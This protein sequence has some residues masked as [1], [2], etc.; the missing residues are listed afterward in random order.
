MSETQPLMPDERRPTIAIIGMGPRGLSVLERIAVRIRDGTMPADRRLVL[1]DAVQIGTGRIWRTDQPRHLLMNTVVSHMSMYSG[2]A[3]D[4]PARAGAGPS[5]YDWHREH[6]DA[7]INGID[8]NGYAKRA[9][10]ARYLQDV[11]QSILA[12]L[13][14]ATVVA[15]VV[16]CVSELRRAHGRYSLVKDDG[17]ELAGIDQV[18]LATGHPNIRPDSQESPLTNFAQQTPGV[19]FVPGDSAA[20]LPLAAV[21]AGTEVGLIGMGLGFY[22]VLLSLTEGRGG[23]FEQDGDGLRYHA[24]GREPHIVA[25]SRSGVPMLARGANQKPPSHRYDPAYFTAEALQAARREATG[26]YG[27]SRLDFKRDVYPLFNAELR[28]V[29][30]KAHARLQFGDDAAEAFAARHDA[31]ELPDAPGNASLFAEYGLSDIKPLDVFELGRPF[32]GQTYDSRAAYRRNLLQLLWDDLAAARE[33]NVDNPLK[34]A[35]DA[36]RDVRGVLRQAVDFEGLTPQAH[37]YDFLG[38]FAPVIAFLSAGPPALRIEQT[39]ALIEAGVLEPVGPETT[40]AGDAGTGTFLAVSG[41]VAGAEHFV[42]TLI[43]TRVPVP[44]VSRDRSQLMRNLLNTGVVR[45]H[46]A[47]DADGPAFV[48]GGVDVRPVSFNVIG[49]DS[50][51]NPNI[52][53]LGLPTEHTR[54]FTQVGSGTPCHCA[55]FTQDAENLVQA[56]LHTEARASGSV[57]T[58]QEAS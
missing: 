27:S 48:T 25:G 35:L 2:P 56:L 21:G 51:A 20:D 37:R 33:G 34:A 26:R 22:D 50:Q 9:V 16:G 29:Y 40:F 3:D 57:D 39:I 8:R 5:L 32:A 52:F 12:H 43:D 11:Y 30:Y 1:I 36:I 7:D 44:D 17:R 49:T 31:R 41:Q 10:Y 46:I 24:S 23:R 54:W 38:R 28:H 19:T 58:I 14:D 4:G 18:V 6:G 47:S 15:E 45:N 42:T 13:P 53:A 55:T